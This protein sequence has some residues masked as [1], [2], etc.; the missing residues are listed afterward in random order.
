MLRGASY[1]AKVHTCGSLMRQGWSVSLTAGHLS[2]GRIQALTGLQAVDENEMSSKVTGKKWLKLPCHEWKGCT[3]ITINLVDCF[4]FSFI[5]LK[6][7]E[8]G[9][10]T[11]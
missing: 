9:A 7:T 10:Y 5:T 11:A 2:L 8:I 1:E 6:L 4:E 3:Y